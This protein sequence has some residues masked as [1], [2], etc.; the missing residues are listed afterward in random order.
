MTIVTLDGATLADAIPL[1]L[2]NWQRHDDVRIRPELDTGWRPF[3]AG[4][5]SAV[6]P[7]T[8][9]LATAR[10]GVDPHTAN[11]RALTRILD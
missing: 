1:M 7:G 11:L 8:D 2:D 4:L 9:R 10:P 6:G 5:A 3:L